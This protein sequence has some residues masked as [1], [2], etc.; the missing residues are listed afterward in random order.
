MANK[1][2]YKKRDEIPL[3][4][5]DMSP[6]FLEYLNEIKDKN[7]TKYVTDYLERNYEFLEKKERVVFD[8]KTVRRIKTYNTK[9][10]KR[11]G[12]PIH[13]YS[14]TYSGIRQ[15]AL[16][17]LELND[18]G[19][20]FY[21]PE[22]SITAVWDLDKKKWTTL[23]DFYKGMRFKPNEEMLK[24]YPGMFKPHKTY[25][26]TNDVL[27]IYYSFEERKD[28][29]K[30]ALYLVFQQVKMIYRKKHEKQRY[31]SI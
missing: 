20:Y 14:F 11:V 31:K 3:P 22:D 21:L 24:V 12:L 28:L 23:P 4:P 15:V 16:T 30:L 26:I 10:L 29:T 18:L 7:K 6:A 13:S 17:G 27:T 5:N 2:S 9:V 1:R 25:K 19:T 8:R